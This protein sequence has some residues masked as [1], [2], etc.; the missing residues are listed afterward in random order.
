[1]AQDSRAAVLPEV[2]QAALP[3][4][5]PGIEAEVP[6]AEYRRNQAQI[7]TK[8]PVQIAMKFSA[9]QGCCVLI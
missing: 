6:G 3:L 9:Q 4:A 8:F 1:V 5:F 2:N 7:A